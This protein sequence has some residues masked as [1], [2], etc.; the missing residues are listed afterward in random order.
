[1]IKVCRVASHCIFPLPGDAAADEAVKAK[2]K[3]DT[4]T[5]VQKLF[6]RIRVSP[7]DFPESPKVEQNEKQPSAPDEGGHGTADSFR[8]IVLSLIKDHDTANV[9]LSYCLSLPA[10]ISVSDDA[11]AFLVLPEAELPTVVKR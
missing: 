4:R 6:D 3:I 2:P 11:N 5:E 8:Q 7:R 9:L 10:L 1:M